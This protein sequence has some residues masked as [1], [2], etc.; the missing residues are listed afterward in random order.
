MHI[1]LIV[2]GILVGLAALFFIHLMIVAFIPGMDVPKQPLPRPDGAPVPGRADPPRERIERRF[3]VE[4]DEVGAWLYFP[5]PAASRVPCVVMGCGAGG[6][7]DM[8]ME[9]YALRF[10]AAGYAVLLFDYRFF[11]ESD[12]EPRQLMWMPHQLADYDAAVDY[13]RTLPEVDADRVILWGTSLSGGHV[14]VRAAD[15]HRVAAAIAQCPGMDG[16]AA[17]LQMFKTQKFQIRPV[18]HA[19]RDFVRSWFGLSAHRI[20]LLGVPGSIAMMTDPDVVAGFARLAS[21][22]FVNEICARI[23][24]RGDKYRP[25]TEARKVRCP[26]LLQICE[27]DT[28]TSN[29]ATEKTARILAALAEVRRYPIGHFDI[30]FGEHFEQSIEDQL[31]F[32]R[33]Q[34]PVDDRA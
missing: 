8:G 28:L 6:T 23:G 26:V 19:Q 16:R 12:G 14:L 10:R 1:L 3:A 34:V 31:A 32:L 24:I 4:G 2:L 30:Y 18:L 29:A 15:D 5:E 33:A 9:Q 27:H 7:K 20:P 13:A 22:D 21:A 25:V 17:A 11:G